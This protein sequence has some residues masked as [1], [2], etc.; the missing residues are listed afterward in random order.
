M[1]GKQWQ[2]TMRLLKWSSIWTESESWILTVEN[3]C[4][5]FT[6]HF[7]VW[8]KRARRER[9]LEEWGRNKRLQDWNPN[10]PHLRHEGN[11]SG[12]LKMQHQ[13][14]HTPPS[15]KSTQTEKPHFKDIKQTDFNQVRAEKKTLIHSLFYSTIRLSSF[16]LMKSKIKFYCIKV[17]V[18]CRLSP[19]K[20]AP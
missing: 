4:L 10:A 20:G 19:E 17:K 18:L 2:T 1:T 11:E 12:C 6:C 5:W 3:V 16:S 8:L 14:D 15:E 13:T 9:R 7:Q